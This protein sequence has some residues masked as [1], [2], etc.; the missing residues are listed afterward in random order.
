M[1]V[2]PQCHTF[3]I[4][5]DFID[6]S[7]HQRTSICRECIRNYY[8]N[9][10]TCKPCLFVGLYTFPTDTTSRSTNKRK[11]PI[12][13]DVQSKLIDGVIPQPNWVCVKRT[14][15]KSS[16]SIITA[17]LVHHRIIKDVSFSS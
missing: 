10:M 17:K 12:S 11:T 15:R 2:C 5:S 7:T 8:T 4:E 1:I 14:S 16:A 6:R 3:R 13:K 9:S